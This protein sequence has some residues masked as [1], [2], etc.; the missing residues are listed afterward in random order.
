MQFYYTIMSLD[1]DGHKINQN[2]M[3]SFLCSTGN[4][5]SLQRNKV[6]SKFCIF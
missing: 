4:N 6:T 3:C 1:N 2:P 5:A